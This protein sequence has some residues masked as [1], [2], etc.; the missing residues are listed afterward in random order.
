VLL[1]HWTIFP[2]PNIPSLWKEVHMEWSVLQLLYR[3]SGRTVLEDS[4]GQ[5]KSP[6]EFGEVSIL[7]ACEIEPFEQEPESC[8]PDSHRGW[9]RTF[10]MTVHLTIMIWMI[11]FWAPVCC[12]LANVEKILRAT[13]STSFTLRKAFRHGDSYSYYPCPCNG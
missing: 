7:T 13:S 8:G 11:D 12:Q 5:G 9:C 1:L 3:A 2:L 4:R 10:G 6:F